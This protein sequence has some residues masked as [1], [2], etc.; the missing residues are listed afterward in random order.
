MREGA[1]RRVFGYCRV[2][3]VGQEKSGTSLE[4]QRDKIAGYCAARGLPAPSL[5]IEVES[6]TASKI[7]A[8]AEQLRLQEEAREG[9]LVL[10]TMLDRWSRDVPH[11]ILTSRALIARGVGWIAFEDSI[12][13]STRDGQLMLQYRAIAAEQERIRIHDRTVGRRRELTD[14][15]L[16][17][18]GRVPIGYRAEGRRL[19]IEPTEAAL[20]RAIFERCVDGESLLDLAASLPMVRKR[21][22]WTNCAVHKILCCRY[23]LGEGRRSD[24]TWAPDTHPA[25]IDAD[26]WERAHA[27]MRSRVH[28]GRKYGNGES[29]VRLLRGL[30]VCAGCGRKVSVRFGARHQRAD[31][32][33]SHAHYYLCRGGLD[34]TCEE[35]WIRAH[36]IDEDV[37]RQVVTHLASLRDLLAQ[38]AT[39]PKPTTGKGADVPAALARLEAQ[40]RRTV[41]LATSGVL[42]ARDAKEA[43]ARYEEQAATLRRRR[44][45]EAEAMAA[46]A[47]ATDPAARATLLRGLDAIRTAWARMTIDDRRGVLVRL[48]ERVEVGR[49]GV[50]CRWRSVAALVG[51]KRPI[52]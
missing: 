40:R 33:G 35:G 47:R 38:P 12:D 17:V 23:V 27:A 39:V 4:G 18:L 13:A 29:K 41:D 3:S 7:E 1:P 42:S 45:R 30:A 37:S 44:D 14:A 34:H 19:H 52:T 5:F 50:K 31:P 36:E 20:V 26:L 8:R 24:G 48:A 15:G 9:D 49:S 10:V 2:S 6:A 28:G 32:G 25:I 43:L 51:G 22:R 21:T 46:E 11:A 16:Y